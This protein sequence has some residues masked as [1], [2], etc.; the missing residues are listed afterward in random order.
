[1][2]G[3]IRNIVTLCCCVAAVLFLLAS[4]LEAAELLEPREMKS[5]REMTVKRLPLKKVAGDNQKIIVPMREPVK[6]PPGKA[7][8]PPYREGEVLVILSCPRLFPQ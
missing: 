4:T 6:S 1:M 8:G 3:K 2:N 7:K 5:I